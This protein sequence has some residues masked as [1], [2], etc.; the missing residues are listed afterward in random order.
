MIHQ[1]VEVD[2]A[3]LEMRVLAGGEPFSRL[4]LH[5]GIWKPVGI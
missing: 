3:R 2:P 1:E 4:W 5:N